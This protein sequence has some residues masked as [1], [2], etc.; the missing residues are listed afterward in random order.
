MIFQGTWTYH[1]ASTCENDTLGLHSIGSY[2]LR[3][4]YTFLTNLKNVIQLFALLL[5]FKNFKLTAM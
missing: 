2:F 3:M 4:E 1:I 5:F